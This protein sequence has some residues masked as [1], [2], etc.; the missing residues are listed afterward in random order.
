MTVV[1]PGTEFY[2]GDFYLTNEV[3]VPFVILSSL[4]LQVVNGRPMWSQDGGGK[5]QCCLFWDKKFRHCTYTAMLYITCT[6]P[7]V[8]WKV[9]GQK[10]EY[11]LRL[12]EGEG[13]VPV[14][15]RGTV[16][17]CQGLCHMCAGMAPGID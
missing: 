8:D 12:D 9:P 4:G 13:V 15:R 2:G 3:A 7:L 1:N 6:Q 14:S 17:M 11:W 10:R 5:Y 16:V